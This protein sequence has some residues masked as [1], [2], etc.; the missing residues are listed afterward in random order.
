MA[1]ESRGVTDRRSLPDLPSDFWDFEPQ[2]GWEPVATLCRE[3][4]DRRDGIVEKIV[5]R[6]MDEVD[7]YRS[8]GGLVLIDELRWTTGLGV[9]GWL[10]GFATREPMTDEAVAYQRF[11]GRQSA[12]RGLALQPVVA[13]YQIGFR[14]LWAM[15]ADRARGTR[16]SELMLEHGSV[17]WERLVEITNAVADG[18]QAEVVRQRSRAASSFE[19]LLELLERGA[20]DSEA[21]QVAV[22]LGFDP[23][24]VFTAAALAD[25]DADRDLTTKVCEAVRRGGHNALGVRR[26]RTGVLLAQA[27]AGHLELA[28]SELEIETPLGV[29][30]TGSG[31]NSAAV[32][33]S[34]ARRALKLATLRSG[35]TT[36]DSDWLTVTV[37]ANLDDVADV[38]E[39]GSR[40]AESNPHL[41]EA[42]S[43]FGDERFNI[44]R[45]SRRLFISPNALRYR[46][47]RW[48]ELTGWNPLNIDGLA[49]SVLAIRLRSIAQDNAPPP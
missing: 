28:V 1:D 11:I 47:R 46:L 12:R 21:S 30:S 13:S 14:E 2:P 35:M 9:A 38:L 41:A 15:L 33:L 17:L 19:H 36:F 44:A 23:G 43:T 45:A 49:A 48:H 26:G 18:Y 8:E 34:R 7:E 29:G 10:R 25:E 5:G 22:E 32:S 27:K 42:V 3:M 4:F 39:V 40:I 20:S 16:A 37:L 31:L 24:G 6:I